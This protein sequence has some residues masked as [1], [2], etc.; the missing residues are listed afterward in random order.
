VAARSLQVFAGVSD[1]GGA[2]CLFPVLDVLAG[3][4]HRVTVCTRPAAARLAGS[5][6]PGVRV[7]PRA[8]WRRVLAG[9]SP[10]VV[11]SSVCTDARFRQDLT[12]EGRRRRLPVVW[13]QDFW[14]SGLTPLDVTR[15]SVVVVPDAF[16]AQLV[17]AHWGAAAAGRVATAPSPA[18]ERLRAR[19]PAREMAALRR[20]WGLGRRPVVLFAGEALG[21]PE[22]LRMLRGALRR[23]G[24]RVDL[25][26]KLHPRSSSASRARSRA[27]LRGFP[28]GTREVDGVPVETLVR[29]AECAV[30]GM[31][32]V[33]VTAVYLRRAAI[34][35]ANGITRTKL[36]RVWLRRF[37]P[38]DRGACAEARSAEELAA[39]L[40]RAA[41]GELRR[42]QRRAQQ[43][44]FPAPRGGAA[45]R[46]AGL[47]ERIANGHGARRSK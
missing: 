22:M 36:G 42:V 20:R 27:V 45:T 37:P 44:G 24:T 14:G 4:G 28:P 8:R 34:S 32:T 43:R 31:S 5:L 2:G 7:R 21:T 23:L 47:V 3:R 17:R 26:V 11:V 25:L 1:P 13:V 12:R 29:L 19:P 10:D 33:L 15:P 9:I 40:A 41:S 6:G 39:L 16:G 46:I 18:F 38:V 30:S 35:L